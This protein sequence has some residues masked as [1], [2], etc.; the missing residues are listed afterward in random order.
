MTSRKEQKQTVKRKSGIGSRWA[1]PWLPALSALLLC[2]AGCGGDDEPEGPR[3]RTVSRTREADFTS[4]QACISASSNQDT[5]LVYSGTYRER[6]RFLGKA[7]TVKSSAGP[8]KTILDG[9]TQD[10]G[11]RGPVVTFD[12]NEGRDSVLQG[13]TIT[14]GFA[15]GGGTV[16]H[17]GGIRILAAGPTVRNCIL[18]ANQAEGDGGGIYCF[19]TGSK[20]KIENV[21]FRGNSAGGQGGALCTVYGAPHLVNCLI[22][23]NEAAEGGALAARYGAVL[24][25]TGC[26]VADNSASL[27]WALYL[28][29]AAVTIREGILWNGTPSGDPIV[30]DFDPSEEDPELEADTVLSLSYLYLRGG[31]DSVEFTDECLE[32]PD[33]CTIDESQGI[34]DTP[35]DPLFAA[36]AQEGT[37][38]DAANGFY[39]SQP[40]AGQAVQSPCVDAGGRTVVQAGSEE[41]TTRTDGIP[42]EGILDLGYHYDATAYVP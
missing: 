4:I 22:F 37:E 2:G 40:A 18:V 8:E 14:N 23:D 41:G 28:R 30:M 17:G 1:R 19:S 35:V 36:R 25:L 16:E 33:R 12:S 39:L 26:T 32:N 15:P 6:I 31:T 21:I 5:C 7:I 11:K 34:L 27:A 24:T 3:T 13:F 10:P 20:P 9:Q 42:D 38:E 29:R